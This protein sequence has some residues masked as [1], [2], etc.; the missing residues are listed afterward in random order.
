MTEQL[1]PQAHQTPL[2]SETIEDSDTFGVVAVFSPD[3]AEAMGAFRED[4]L[5]ADDAW[6][7]QIDGEDEANG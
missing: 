2:H 3:E 5:S 7:S 6:D 1:E 4:A